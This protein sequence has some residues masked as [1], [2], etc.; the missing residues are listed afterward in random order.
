MSGPFLTLPT[1][2]DARAKS[3]SF[4]AQAPFSFIDAQALQ[5]L[6]IEAQRAGQCN[7][8][9]CLH[10]DPADAFHDMLIL[11]HRN[12]YYR[13]HKHLQKGETHHIVK[14][15]MAVFVFN[16]DGTVAGSTVLRRD[17]GS[18][19]SRVGSGMW[20][21]VL[22]LSEIVIYHESKPG[23]FLGDADRLFPAWAPTGSD[24]AESNQ[25]MERLRRHITAP[26]A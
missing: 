25:Y 14:G 18:T 3:L 2:T 19:I 12:R 15:E 13:P 24:A 26:F 5:Q 21:T 6:E 1:R 4:Y 16:E 11:E 10:T 17:G 7:A 9:I 23:P 8:R 20:H 22:P